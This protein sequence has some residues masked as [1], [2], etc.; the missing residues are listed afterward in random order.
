MR[1][2]GVDISEIRRRAESELRSRRK[3]AGIPARI[4]NGRRGEGLVKM[5]KQDRPR[6]ENG[7]GRMP[8]A[9]WAGI[10][11][12]GDGEMRRGDDV[13]EGEDIDAE[14]QR[15][16]GS[17]RRNEIPPTKQA[18][19]RRR[20]V[21]RESSWE[22]KAIRGKAIPLLSKAECGCLSDDIAWRE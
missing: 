14:F 7:R 16:W 4:I 13:S 19:P 3:E 9:R 12:D 2:E 5:A 8:K 18:I 15:R 10:R 17:R 20:R 6:D 22:M 21:R 1:G 11:T